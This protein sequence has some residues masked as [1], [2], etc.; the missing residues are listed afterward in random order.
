MVAVRGAPL[1]APVSLINRS[2]NP[3]IAA[4]LCLVSPEGGPN[5]GSTDVYWL[6]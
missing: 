2:T 4:T 1:G 5:R 3:R 6:V